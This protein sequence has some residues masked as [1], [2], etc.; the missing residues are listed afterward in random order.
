MAQMPNGTRGRMTQRPNGPNAEW[1]TRSNDPK[2][3]WPKCRMA[4]ELGWNRGGGRVNR[5]GVAG[6]GERQRALG[7][8]AG[9]ELLEEG[10]VR[11]VPHHGKFPPESLTA[12]AIRNS[13]L[14]S[15]ATVD[16]HVSVQTEY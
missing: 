4:H 10:A 13:L 14:P 7:A 9:R 15:S 3:E 12:A 6:N 16:K 5:G 2:A 11:L 8:A 1:H